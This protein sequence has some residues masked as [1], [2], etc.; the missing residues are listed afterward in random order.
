MLYNF[1]ICLCR[2]LFDCISIVLRCNKVKYVLNVIHLH[3]KKSFRKKSVIFNSFVF[4]FFHRIDIHALA[5][6]LSQIVLCLEP[7]LEKYPQ[8]T[9][10]ILRYLIVD[11]SEQLHMYFNELHFLP[12]MEALQDINETIEK[13]THI[14]GSR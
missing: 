13:H 12:D 5:P 4:M 11:H 8:E 6:L 9:S 1:E 10:E 14:E 2:N 3:L 7:V